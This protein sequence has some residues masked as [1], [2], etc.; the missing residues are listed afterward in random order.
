MAVLAIHPGEDPAEELKELDMNAAALARRPRVRT[1]FGRKALSLSD[2][3]A[4]GL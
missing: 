1:L 4:T 2:R 3:I